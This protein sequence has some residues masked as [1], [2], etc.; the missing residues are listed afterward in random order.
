MYTNET[1]SPATTYLILF[2]I[3]GNLEVLQEGQ[4]HERVEKTNLTFVGLL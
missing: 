1:C 3:Y 2:Q 4:I